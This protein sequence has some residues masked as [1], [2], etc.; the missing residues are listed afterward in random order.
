MS[1]V[2]NVKGMFEQGGALSKALP[3]FEA[4]DPQIQMAVIVA[5]CLEDAKKGIIQ[6]GV[7]TGKTFGYALPAAL[8]AVKNQKRVV[9]STNTK[10]LQHQLLQN[11]LPLIQKILAHEGYSFYFT[12]SKGQS[13]YLCMKKLHEFQ[14]SFPEH[15]ITNLMLQEIIANPDMV[16]DRNSFPFEIPI[17]IWQQLEANPRECEENDNPFMSKCFSRKSKLG[18][19]EAHVIVTNH[20]MFFSDLAKRFEGFSVLPDYDVVIFDEAHRVDDVFTNFFK[21]ELSLKSMEKKFEFFLTRKAQW[22]EEVFKEEFLI[23]MLGF[24]DEILNISVSLFKTIQ[25]HL[26]AAELQSV[27]LE[28]SVVKQNPFWGVY[29]EMTDYIRIMANVL[30]PDED[31]KFRMLSMY[32]RFKKH[33]E[34][35]EFMLQM[36]NSPNWAYWVELE[37]NDNP[38]REVTFTAV[39][40][41]PKTVLYHVYDLATVV[42]TSGTVAPDGDFNYTAGRLGLVDYYSLDVKSP[43]DHNKQSHLIIPENIENEL[44]LENAETYYD[45]LVVYLQQILT[46]SRGSTFILFTSFEAIEEV[47]IRLEFWADT[48]GLTL[49]THQQGVN[50]DKLL[51]SFIQA[52]NGV[53]L[54]AESFWEG[55]NVPGDDLRVVVIVKIPFPNPS[56]IITKARMLKLE[57]EGKNSF[58]HLS[59]PIAKMKLM[60][61]TGRLIRTVQ[62]RG[63]I[64][65]LDPRFRTKR[66]GAE[67][68]RCLPNA[69]RSKNIGDIA[70]YF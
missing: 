29:E 51:E 62:D 59:M 38:A 69:R 45:K 2:D 43:F 54:G 1:F 33:L 55:I 56:D 37:Q 14:E 22:M 13:N 11:D 41:Q 31:T 52:D 17:D 61:G 10:S 9:I 47:R 46:I 65:L 32:K 20:A 24:R 57:R 66:Y 18:I 19:N 12:E 3:G 16:G 7:G 67:L 8:F 21:E 15:E 23:K 64:V 48:E 25:K 35:L 5:K 58:K 42:F 30:A 39:P 63:A 60:Q 50:R 27:I 28:Q 44:D 53:L 6:A 40:Y 49:Y 26:S 34:S 68:L 36:Q 4:R 70:K